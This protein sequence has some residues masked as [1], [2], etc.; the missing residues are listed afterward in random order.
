MELA[1]TDLLSVI[2]KRGKI[3]EEQSRVW[4]HEV[5]QGVAY[6]HSRHYSHRDLKV[7]NVL[8]SVENVALISDFGFVKESDPKVLSSTYCG[9]VQYAAPEILMNTPYDPFAADVWSLGICVFATLTGHMPFQHDT[10]HLLRSEQKIRSEQ[11]NGHLLRSEQKNVER[12]LARVHVSDGARD[13]LSKML[14]HR[15]QDR[16]KMKDALAHDWF[17]GMKLHSE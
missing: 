17:K 4:F 6:L 3:D 7:E 16:I 2:E 5:F 8:I 1:K 13:L 15:E 11:K 10:I 9:S 12:I 14:K